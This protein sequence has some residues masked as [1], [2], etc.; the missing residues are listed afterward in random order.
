[1]MIEY[2]CELSGRKALAAV[3]AALIEDLTPAFGRHARAKTMPALADE[4][5]RL[6]R[7]FHF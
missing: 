2:S 5:A 3:C 4:L 7:P 1:M 6:V